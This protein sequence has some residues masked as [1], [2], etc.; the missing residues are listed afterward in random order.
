MFSYDLG[1]TM[2]HEE[3]HMSS[4]LCKKKNCELLVI[5]FILVL[6]VDTYSGLKMNLPVHHLKIGVSVT[7]HHRCLLQYGATTNLIKIMSLINF[8]YMQLCL[9]RFAFLR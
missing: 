6:S 1:W 7:V 8:I 4:I 3:I 5:R 2:V 9:I